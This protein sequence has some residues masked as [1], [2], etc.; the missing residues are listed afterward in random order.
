V[1]YSHVIHTIKALPLVI[2]KLREKIITGLN[3]GPVVASLKRE[4]RSV[5][6]NALLWARLTDISQQVVW[7]GEKLSPE[8]WKHVLTAG[9]K[10]QKA[11]QGIDGGFVILGAS[12]SKMDKREFSELLELALFFGDSQQVKWRD[13]R[14]EDAY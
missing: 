1:S 10:K 14:Y 6:A 3:K 13:T 8:E 11:V 7:N 2:P 5:Q 9:L 12:T 4:T